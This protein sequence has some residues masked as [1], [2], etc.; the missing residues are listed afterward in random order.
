MWF[1]L[2]V[3]TSQNWE[4]TVWYLNTTLFVP[5]LIPC[6]TDTVIT[7]CDGNHEDDISIIT[8]NNRPYIS[9]MPRCSS[10]SRETAV[11]LPWWWVLAVIG[12][13]VW[14]LETERG[15]HQA[16]MQKRS[17]NTLA[18]SMLVPNPPLLIKPV[19]CAGQTNGV[20]SSGGRLKAEQEPLTGPPLAFLNKEPHFQQ[21][22][23]SYILLWHK[24]LLS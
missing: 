9:S 17:W 13:T 18:M 12:G 7:K 3:F 19:V 11:S 5:V 15:I 24:R 6:N 14:L 21:I 10:A 16:Q 22:N 1:D 20:W 4:H 23:L 8:N 2:Q